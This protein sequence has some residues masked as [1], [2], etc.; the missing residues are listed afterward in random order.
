MN[1][2]DSYVV[3]SVHD[4]RAA[5]LVPVDLWQFCIEILQKIATIQIARNLYHNVDAGKKAAGLT[6]AGLITIHVPTA[7]QPVGVTDY[8]QQTAIKWSCLFFCL[9]TMT[10][11]TRTKPSLAT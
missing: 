11:M 10:L 3:A 8:R 9:A 6:S 4:E 5:V 1:F 7:I 2:W